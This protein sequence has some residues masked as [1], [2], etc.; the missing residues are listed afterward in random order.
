MC[1]QVPE[2]ANHPGPMSHRFASERTGDEVDV[3]LPNAGLLREVLV[4]HREWPEGL[5]GEAP[6]VREHRDLATLGGDD[7]AVGEQVI[8]QVDV[9][10]EIGERLRPDTRL[11]HH[12]LEALALAILDRSRRPVCPCP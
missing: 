5:G 7:P 1:R 2:G 8:A 9:R 3:P 6:L 11:A 10:L 4:E 12:D